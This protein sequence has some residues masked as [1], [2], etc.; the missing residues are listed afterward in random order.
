MK[1]TKFLNRIPKFKIYKNNKRKMLDKR[2]ILN[3]LPIE[4]I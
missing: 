1:L 2:N 4:A 3:K